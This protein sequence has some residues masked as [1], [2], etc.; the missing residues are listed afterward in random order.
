MQ[1]IAVLNKCYFKF[2]NFVCHSL[3][4]LNCC[5]LSDAK[6]WHDIG[7]IYRPSAA[8]F[9]KYRHRPLKN[10]YR[11][12]TI[13]YID[14][15]A[16]GVIPLCI[17]ANFAAQS[18]EGKGDLAFVKIEMGNLEPKSNVGW[19]SFHCFTPHFPCQVISVSVKYHIFPTINCS[20]HK[21]HCSIVCNFIKQI[22]LL[23]EGYVIVFR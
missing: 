10:Q 23:C 4:L 3:L 15:T 14:I 1:T 13:L 12:T 17:R 20:V 21:P 9:S 7:I 6:K 11:S 8:M 18:L 5:I 2:S 19:V 16:L 22:C